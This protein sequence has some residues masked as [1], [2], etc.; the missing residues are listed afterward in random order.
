MILIYKFCFFISKFIKVVS[1][2]ITPDHH[3]LLKASLP[4][5][6]LFAVSKYEPY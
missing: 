4:F 3:I 1:A 6:A 2:I 5:D